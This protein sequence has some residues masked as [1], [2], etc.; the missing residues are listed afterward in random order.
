MV[1]NVSFKV[2]CCGASRHLALYCLF[3][4]FVA[5]CVFALAATNERHR[6]T[7]YAVRPFRVR[8]FVYSS[9]RLLIRT[10]LPSCLLLSLL[11]CAPT[12]Q[13]HVELPKGS[14]EGSTKVPARFTKIAKGFHPNFTC[15]VSYPVTLKSMMN[16]PLPYSHAFRSGSMALGAGEPAPDLVASTLLPMVSLRKQGRTSPFSS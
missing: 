3:V 13:T 6:V 2:L 14:A 15:I 4:F 8:S 10:L 16:R 11:C 5:F 12:A 1:E 9:V 7:G